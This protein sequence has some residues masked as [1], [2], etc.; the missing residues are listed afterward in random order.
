M[1]VRHIAWIMLL[2]GCGR[3]APPPGMAWVPGGE[4]MMGS[5]APCER[6]NE[7]PAHRVRV[8]GFWIDR[9]EVTNARF[10]DFVAA[11]GYVTMAE[12]PVDWET[13]KE[14]MPAGTP[15]PPADKLVPGSLVFVPPPGPV[16][17]TDY[18]RWWK[19]TAGADWRHPDGPASDLAGRDDHPVVHVSW[20]DAA[21]F[22]R[23]AGGRLPTEAEWEFAARGGLAGKR[24]EWGDETPTDA[25]GGRANVWQGDFPHRNRKVDGFAGTAP[26]GRF[27]ANGYGLHD[28][29]GNVWEWCG[30]WY[31]PDAYAG[32]GK[33]TVNPTGPGGSYDPAEPGVPKRVSRG[34]SFLCHATYCESYRPAARQG[35]AADTGSSHL[36]FR[37]VRPGG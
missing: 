29:S 6:H 26:V 28:L 27:P 21:A 19:W 35:T 7:G 4:F 22:V 3:P 13:L 34:G 20:E 30:D 17:L 12:K 10:R 15:K 9:H 33:L 25:D 36:G 32:R 16:P 8:A 1:S 14:Q 37:C 23:W 31:R 2:A 11:T 18:G 24:F 5:N